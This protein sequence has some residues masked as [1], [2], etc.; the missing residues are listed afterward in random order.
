MYRSGS[1]LSQY[2][3]VIV[4]FSSGA[5]GPAKEA[6]RACYAAARAAKTRFYSA[7]VDFSVAV[8]FSFIAGRSSCSAAVDFSFILRPQIT[9]Y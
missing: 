2:I 7:A 8:D 9:V 1:G 6:G 5:Q 3:S 4:K